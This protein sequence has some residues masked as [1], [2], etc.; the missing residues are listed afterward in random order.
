MPSAVRIFLLACIGVTFAY[1]LWHAGEPLRL[2]IGD[3]WSD[4]NVLSSINYVKQYGFLETSFTD[5]LDVGPLTADSYRYIHYPPLAEIFYGATAKYLGVSDIGTFRLFALGFSGLAMILLFQYTRRIWN[6]SVALIATALFTTSLFWMMYAD[7]MHQAPVMQASAFLALWGLVRAIET[8]LP[9][10]YAAAFLGSLACFL[11]S[12]DY[13]L[14]LPAAVLFT[15][16]SKL[17][18]PFAPG[19]RHFVVLCALGCLSGILI[20]CAF[21]IGAVGWEEFVAD[22]HLQF[23]ERSTSTYDRKFASPLSTLVRRLTLVFSP[24]FWVTAG[25]TVWRA[26][27]A[28]SLVSVIKDGV[29]W[30]LVVALMFL[31]LFSQLAASQML[32]SQPLLPFYAIG[33]ALLVHQLIVDGGT[34]RGL[35]IAWLVFAPVWSFYFMLS[36]PRSVLDRVDVAKVNTYMATNDRNDFMM[37]NL[38]SDGHVQAS[39]QRHY[40]PTLDAADPSDAPV[41]MLRVFEITGTD[42]VHAAVFTGPDSRFIDKSLWPLA[43]PRRLWSVTGWPHL[44]RTKA[45]KII[46]EYDKNVLANLKEVDAQK[47][48]QLSNFAIYRIDRKTVLER[49]FR[50]VPVVTSID[51][52]SLTSTRHKLLGWTGPQLTKD[53]QLGISS[54]AGHFTCPNVSGPASAAS[55]GPNAC[56]TVLTK[57]GL[58]MKDEQ[59]VPKAELMLRLERS[60][61]VQLSFELASPSLIEVSVNGFSGRQPAPSRKASFVV[62]S[63]SIRPG[64]NIVMVEHLLGDM[65]PSTSVARI[66]ITQAC[67]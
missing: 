25:L 36:H 42:H 11:T 45:N 58:Q 66:D 37:S 18:N 30:I 10:H 52:G 7:S 44:Y 54:I 22:L 2:N 13:W 51:L 6:E 28:P 33:S 26:I 55:P 43:M 23:L 35:A 34:R 57:L 9:R 17:G 48:L 50:N 32:A 53:G 24:L 1:L 29:A 47:V 14:F 20:K 41:Q 16:Y 59:F 19:R 21:V 38:L 46:A 67:P 39:F 4:A 12:Y 64:V 31:Y 56:K 8:R 27:R 3:P 61:D 15:V 5:I 63:A 40:W 62:P 65:I 60:C 49:V